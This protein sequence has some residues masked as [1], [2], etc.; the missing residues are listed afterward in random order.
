MSV[1][2]IPTT[3][4]EADA[5][6]DHGLSLRPLSAA[7][8]ATSS[9]REEELV[10]QLPPT[11]WLRAT[12][13]FNGKIQDAEGVVVLCHG[14]CSWRNQILIESLARGLVSPRIATL[15]FDFR[16]NGSSSDDW[17]Y[18]FSESRDIEDVEAVLS[19][20]E[21]ELEKPVLALAGHSQ[22]SKTILNW[23]R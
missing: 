19:F 11:S 15:R 8:S 9:I 3:A 4:A 2:P 22:G 6:Y 17:G 1:R 13:A 14:L 12:L 20:I 16:G 18:D 21:N 7:V 10:I 5:L 23:F